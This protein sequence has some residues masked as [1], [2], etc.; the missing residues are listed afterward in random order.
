MRWGAMLLGWVVAMLPAAPA[1]AQELPAGSYLSSCQQ[2]KIRSGRDLA[3][4]CATRDGDWVVALLE[5]FSSCDGD[6]SNKDGQLTCRRGASLFG[7][8]SKVVATPPREAGRAAGPSSPPGSYLASCREA[9]AASGWLKAV[10]QD[11][12]GR[13]IESTLAL[14]T[15]ADGSDIL[16]EDDAL[17]CRNRRPEPSAVPR[18]SYQQSCRNIIFDGGLLH[19]TCQNRLGGWQASSYYV[20]F[21]GGRDIVNT[22]G[23]LGCAAASAGGY[24][25]PPPPGS[26]LASCQEVVFSG[27]ALRARC[28]DRDGSLRISG[29]L[30][31]ATCPRGGDIYNDNGVLRCGWPG[32]SPTSGER[33]P[34][35]SYTAT[36][37]DIRV[38]AGWLKASC[39][40]RNGRFVDATTAVS[41]CPGGRD[42]ANMDGRLTC[43]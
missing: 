13:W 11:R 9:R 35:G 21:C 4:V 3:A 20:S 30:S 18:G 29:P 2:A 33:P 34:P 32:S 38:V 10:C 17:K 36:C 28:R 24:G 5:N 6:I 23:S 8:G 1:V 16:F 42:I 22:D 25:E 40:D 12:Y 19:A 37:R 7:F 43:R 14:N 31:A 39:K 27:G 26:Y 15:C 41:W